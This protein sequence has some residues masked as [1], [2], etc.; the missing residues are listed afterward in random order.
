MLFTQVALGLLTRFAKSEAE[1]GALLVTVS[2]TLETGLGPVVL[3]G[4]KAA[5]FLLLQTLCSRARL[6]QAVAR[7]WLDL[8]LAHPMPGHP[9]ASLM[10]TGLLVRRHGLQLSE[11]DLQR[12][13][14]LEEQLGA[15]A[16]Q[17]SH[18]QAV[19][20]RLR[21]E[22]EPEVME[23]EEEEVLQPAVEEEEEERKVSDLLLA[24]QGLCFVRKLFFTSCRNRQRR[25]RRTLRSAL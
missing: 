16:R 22:E 13:Q 18:L 7:R 4:Q 6:Q 12:L 15:A 24:T 8:V 10:L 14:E 1:L 9:E 19:L 25:S 21:L 3:P 20:R 5:S 11:A 23:V 2:P 17:E